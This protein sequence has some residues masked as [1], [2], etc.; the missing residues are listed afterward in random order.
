MTDEERAAIIDD[1]LENTQ[2]YREQ[3][4]ARARIEAPQMTEEQLDAHWE[5]A[6][7]IF[8]LPPTPGGRLGQRR[9]DA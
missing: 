4:T 1:I 7:V 3:C 6:E 8:G 9:L 5:F 2:K